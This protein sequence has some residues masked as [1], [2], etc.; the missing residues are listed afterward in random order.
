MCRYE[1][2]V[3][4]TVVIMTYKMI[5]MKY[6]INSHNTTDHDLVFHRPRN[7]SS[8]ERHRRLIM[9]S[10]GR[11]AIAHEYTNAGP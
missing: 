4:V 7:F 9:K 2:F 3:R 6:K 11:V 8:Y 5:A 1:K 10:G